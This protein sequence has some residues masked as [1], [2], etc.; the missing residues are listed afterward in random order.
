MDG[1]TPKYCACSDE[2]IDAYVH[3]SLDTCDTE[4]DCDEEDEGPTSKNEE[5]DARI[6]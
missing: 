3:S 5:A 1:E 2:E 4:G 6:L